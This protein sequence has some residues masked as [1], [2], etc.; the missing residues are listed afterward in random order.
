M[1]LQQQAGGIIAAA[2]GRWKQCISYML[3]RNR[4]SSA[5]CLLSEETHWHSERHRMPH[6]RCL[7]TTYGG[8][9]KVRSG[10]RVLH[11]MVAHTAR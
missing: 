7:S 3:S 11:C 2:A 10:S 4:Y 8:S 5:L 9:S 6:S 1:L